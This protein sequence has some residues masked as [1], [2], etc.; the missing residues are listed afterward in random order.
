MEERRRSLVATMSGQQQHAASTPGLA[1]LVT[2]LDQVQV[3]RQVLAG[4]CVLAFFTGHTPKGQVN[5]VH[6]SSS[7][8]RLEE[9]MALLEHEVE[10]LSHMHSLL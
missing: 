7:H 4:A 8:T 2:A 9:Q 6:S 5:P 10:R 3:A 1:A